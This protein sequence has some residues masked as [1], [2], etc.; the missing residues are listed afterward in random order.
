[1]GSGSEPSRRESRAVKPSGRCSEVW[2]EVLGV[3]EVG[4]EDNFFELGGDSILSLQV[5]ARARRMGLRVT[6]K[7]VFEH[8]TIA[9]AGR[10]GRVADGGGGGG[11]ARGGERGGEADADT[12]VDVGAGD[13]GS[14]SLQPGGDGG[15]GQW[16]ESRG[17]E[18]GGEEAGRAPRRAEDEVQAGGRRGGSRRTWA[19]EREEVV[20]EVD[21]RGVEEGEEA[22]GDKGGG[23][24]DTEEFGH[25]ER[26][27]DKGRG[28]GGGK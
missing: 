5:V 3:E 11:R 26:A 10:G 16:G 9:E 15:G 1:M 28:D 17:G 6:P 23:G 12:G 2:K 20:E 13:G 22:R 8:P 19:E 21:L 24:E 7:Q 4:V 18:G 25:R 27:D 14:E